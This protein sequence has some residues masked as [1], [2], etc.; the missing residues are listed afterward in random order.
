MKTMPEL[1]D[2]STDQQENGLEARLVV[3]RDTASR[4]GLTMQDVD[5][6]LYDAF[7]QRQVSTM[8]TG[9]NQYY[10]VMEVDP[11]YQMSPDALD[12]I[13]IK[14]SNVSG[15]PTAMSSIATAPTSLASTSPAVGG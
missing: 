13:Y 4:L 5:N 3:D 15:A 7:G 8:Y 2:A 1:R 6:V 9:L 14:A 12:N 10:V 11:K